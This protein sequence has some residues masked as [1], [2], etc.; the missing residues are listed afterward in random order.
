MKVVLAEPLGISAAYLETLAGKL[1]ERGCEF[2]AYDTVEKDIE[3]LKKRCREADILIIAN[4]PLPDEVIAECPNLQFISVAFV[5]IDHIGKKTCRDRDIAVSN[6]AGYCNDAVAEL[7]LG[8]T[9][10]C[11]RNISACN[12]VIRRGGNKAGLVGNELRGKTV[13]IIGTGGIGCTAAKL[14]R[15]FGCSLLG[16]S[17][18]ESAA[19]KEIGI[20]YVSLEELLSRS[21]IVSVHVPLTDSTKALLDGDKLALMK[22][23]A[24]LI[25]TARGPVVEQGALAAALNAGKIA[26]AGIDVF[27]TEPPLEEDNVLLQAKNVVC[28]PHVAFA[29]EES[30]NRRAEIVFDNVLTFMDGNPKN[31]MSLE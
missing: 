2:T 17:R 13:G 7:A 21:D 29:T 9:L 1:R 26:A 11:L 30:I 8:L 18:S 19:A 22:E 31:R 12:D 10:D 28:T 20:E 6:A 23:T 27:D 15:A 14:Y 24:I 3:K 4:N 25:N 5:G 16:Y